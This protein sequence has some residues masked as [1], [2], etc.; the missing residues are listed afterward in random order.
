VSLPAAEAL[1]GLLV[2]YLRVVLFVMV[3]SQYFMATLGAEFSRLKW[4]GHRLHAR[5]IGAD[6]AAD[7]APELQLRMRHLARRMQR[8]K[9]CIVM[10]SSSSSA[11][12]PA[13]AAAC[14]AG[15][16]STQGRS[17]SSSAAAL[18]LISTCMPHLDS[19][20]DIEQD[21]N[22]APAVEV[23][24]RQL[25]LLTLQQLLLQL[26]ADS[27]ESKL[28]QPQRTS[29]DGTAAVASAQPLDSPESTAATA[30]VAEAEDRETVGSNAVSAEVAAAVAAQ[31]LA[32]LQGMT[33]DDSIVEALQQT[34]ETVSTGLTCTPV[35]TSSCPRYHCCVGCLL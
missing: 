11:V 8:W 20:N 25:D 21:C 33:V 16:H 19:S 4:L 31:L 7:I 14:C 18:H 27:Q 15:S 22:S 23:F 13:D 29:A 10:C 6:V 3:L 17:T 12:V 28:P 5:S 34:K 2:Y 32:T 1:L 30:T 24:G 26:A 9:G 35:C